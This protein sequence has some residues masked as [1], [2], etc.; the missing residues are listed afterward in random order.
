L[1]LEWL[2]LSHRGGGETI[3]SV[4]VVFKKSDQ[5]NQKIE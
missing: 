2:V 4:R 1:D 5:R 3:R